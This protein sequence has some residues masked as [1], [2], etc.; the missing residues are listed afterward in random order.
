MPA[1]NEQTDNVRI[2]KLEPWIVTTHA[3]LAENGGV[4]LEEHLRELLRKQA[5]RAQHEMADDLQQLRT[6]LAEQF[7]SN[8]PNSVE[9][10]RAVRDESDV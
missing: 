10:V 3:R 1:I 2:R 9:L 5:L 6:E 7:G 8:F 4:S